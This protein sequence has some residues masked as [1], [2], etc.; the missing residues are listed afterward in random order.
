MLY[1]MFVKAMSIGI[2]KAA[3]CMPQNLRQHYADKLMLMRVELEYG[4]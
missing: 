1:R 3:A 2:D 4:L